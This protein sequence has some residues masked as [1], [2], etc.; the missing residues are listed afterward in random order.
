MRKK[1][2]YLLVII[3]TIVFTLIG[4]PIFEAKYVN[5]FIYVKITLIICSNLLFAIILH[6]RLEEFFRTEYFFYK[7][8]GAK[9][10]YIIRT[11][12]C[13][14]EYLFLLIVG[15]NY[16]NVYEK[17]MIFASLG[18]IQV[19]MIYFLLIMLMYL[20]RHIEW[21]R[22]GSRF[23]LFLMIFAESSK[24][25]LESLKLCRE[26]MRFMQIVEKL[27]GSKEIKAVYD[28]LT[29]MNPL[30]GFC[31]FMAIVVIYKL[32]GLSEDCVVEYN[33]GKREKCNNRYR[34]SKKKKIAMYLGTE[35]K[36][37]FRK[38]QNIF[39]YL[40]VYAILLYVLCFI[41]AEKNIFFV[42]LVCIFG[43]INYGVECVYHE[44]TRCRRWYQVLGEIYQNFLL[45]KII[46]TIILNLFAIF[47]S[48]IKAFVYRE[49]VR[50]ELLI[51]LFASFF[52]IYWNLY[53]TYVYWRLDNYSSAKDAFR[54]WM[55]L[56]LMLLPGIN[57]MMC[58][59][60]YKRGR[61]YW[62]EY[63]GTA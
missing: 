18:A 39:S 15:V 5:Q 1:V 21:M 52:V 41:K 13:Q 12:F 4:H 61:K 11:I 23:L 27:C 29:V 50:T 20:G 14:N 63:I 37:T 22:R 33:N 7:M 24:L 34:R 28:L 46:T 49:L 30:K 32:L 51:L 56:I 19:L 6:T 2:L 43:L 54:S 40:L 59:F 60:Y 3:F 42:I 62:D 16:F 38:I 45:K 57:L 26:N 48:L 36:I 10:A 44:D 17:N 47:V 25:I 8:I 58:I 31:F 53:Y 35:I 55:A 9:P